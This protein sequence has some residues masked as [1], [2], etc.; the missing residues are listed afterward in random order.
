[1]NEVK[2]QEHSDISDDDVNLFKP[3]L[4]EL[5]GNVQ[6]VVV[7]TAWVGVYAFNLERVSQYA[8]PKSLKRMTFKGKWLKDAFTDSVQQSIHDQ[9]WKAEYDEANKKLKLVR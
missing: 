1:M 5:F 6:E 8:L 9:G 7:V 4:F 3:V 2:K